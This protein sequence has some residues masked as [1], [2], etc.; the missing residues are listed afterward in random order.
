MCSKSRPLSGYSRTQ[1]DAATAA[2]KALRHPKS[3]NIPKSSD[4]EFFF[5]FNPPKA[6]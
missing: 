6:R 3:G 4:I 1:N 5:Y 2:L